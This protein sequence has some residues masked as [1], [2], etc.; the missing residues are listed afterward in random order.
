M[1]LP[2]GNDGMD[3]ASEAPCV[4]LAVMIIVFGLLISTAWVI[5]RR[6]A[7]FAWLPNV[8]SLLEEDRKA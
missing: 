5:R 8:K 2:R 1:Q 3:S 4:L 7:K 6:K